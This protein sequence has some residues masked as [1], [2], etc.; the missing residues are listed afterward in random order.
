MSTRSTPPNWK[1]LGLLYSY[2]VKPG[3]SACRTVVFFFVNNNLPPD[4]NCRWMNLHWHKL[5]WLWGKQRNQDS[6]S[7]HCYWEKL[8]WGCLA[9]IALLERFHEAYY[10]L[11]QEI[12]KMSYE[13]LTIACR[14]VSCRVSSSVDHGLKILTTE[15]L[16]RSRLSI[17]VKSPSSLGIVPLMLLKPIPV[18][19]DSVRN[20]SDEPW[21]L[22]F[23]SQK[24]LFSL[25][26][27][28]LR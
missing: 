9:P 7:S 19:C 28:K 8:D 27:K 4:S 12:K 14:R 24:K 22:S 23:F 25:T 5:R 6:H 21:T 2:L 18:I 13:I 3:K 11:A 16:Q 10:R 17:A 26:Q 15:N 1:F 20:L